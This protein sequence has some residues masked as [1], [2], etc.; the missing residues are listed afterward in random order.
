M[1]VGYYIPLN[2]ILHIFD[3]VSSYVL[4]EPMFDRAKGVVLAKAFEPLTKTYLRAFRKAG[5]N[6]L[7]AIDTSS[8]DG[9]IIRCLKKDVSRNKE[10]ALKY[11]RL[12]TGDKVND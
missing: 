11:L 4:V 10:D 5:I 12:M 7:R 1:V 8:D 3:N 2:I 6:E 9:A